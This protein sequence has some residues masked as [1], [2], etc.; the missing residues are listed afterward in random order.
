MR[1]KHGQ[2]CCRVGNFTFIFSFE[3]KKN[4][5]KNA[6]NEELI[7]VLLPG[8][9]STIR[10]KSDHLGPIYRSSINAAKLD[11]FLNPLPHHAAL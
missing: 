3:K 10:Q 7:S 9:T 2:S 11:Q 4:F 1:L 8:Y 6:D 5:F